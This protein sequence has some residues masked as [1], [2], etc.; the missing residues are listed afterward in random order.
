MKKILFLGG[1][2]L[3]AMT[4]VSCN[5]D[6]DDWADPQSNPQEEAVTLPGYTATAADPIDLANPGTSVKAFTLSAA[7][8]PEG[9]TIEHTRV[10]LLPADGSS[11]TK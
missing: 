9:A 10:E 3:S 5:G 1:L 6:Y 8:L 4:F 7:T 11:A 2:L